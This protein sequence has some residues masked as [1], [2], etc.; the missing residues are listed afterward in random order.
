MSA[1]PVRQRCNDKPFG[2][3]QE[4]ILVDKAHICNVDD[5]LVWVLIEVETALLQPFK[6]TGAFDMQPA[7]G[8]ERV[9]IRDRE[10][11]KERAE[12]DKGMETEVKREGRWHVKNKKLKGTTQKIIWKERWKPDKRGEERWKGGMCEEGFRWQEGNIKRVEREE[13]QESGGWT[14]RSWS[15][16]GRK[17]GKG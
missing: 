8:G 16:M 5:H 7:L 13:K 3:P 17:E 6:V 11:G 9:A 12:G 10:R 4:F 1:L 2:T 15:E 14:K